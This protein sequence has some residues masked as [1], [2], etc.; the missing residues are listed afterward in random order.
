MKGRVEKRPGE[1]ER[2][3]S[4][5]RGGASLKEA[6]KLMERPYGTIADWA[7]REDMNPAPAGWSPEEDKALRHQFMAG[8]WLAEIAESLG[9]SY[10]SVKARRQRLRLVR[11]VEL[12]PRR[13]LKPSPPPAAR[14][15]PARSVP[16]PTSGPERAWREAYLNGLLWWGP[17]VPS[18]TITPRFVPRAAYGSS[19]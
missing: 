11:G 16:V 18:S 3:E 9:R 10:H 17:D 6:A 7:R 15:C 8:R 14:P 5:L 1:I 2:L 12:Q 4:L 19:V 13:R